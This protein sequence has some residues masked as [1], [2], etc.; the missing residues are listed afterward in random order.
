MYNDIGK[1]LHTIP[2]VS[3]IL[4]ASLIAEIG[5]INKFSNSSKLARYAGI[6]PIEKSSG[7]KDKSLKSEFGNRKLNSLVYTIACIGLS[8]G[9][10]SGENLKANNPIFKEY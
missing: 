10:T 5:N 3:N 4:A 7:G 2:C 6:A 9:R 8:T 1:K